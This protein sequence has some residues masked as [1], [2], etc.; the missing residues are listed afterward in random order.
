MTLATNKGM[1]MADAHRMGIVGVVFSV[2]YW[3][4][5][6]TGNG[7]FDFSMDGPAARHA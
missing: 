3:I 5:I 2:I 1:A 6:V 7:S 4:L